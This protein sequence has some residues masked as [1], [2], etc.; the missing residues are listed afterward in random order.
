MLIYIRNRR[1][2]EFK[3]GFILLGALE[4]TFWIGILK[5]TS[6][7]LYIK[8]VWVDCIGYHNS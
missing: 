7:L 3:Y 4:R 5:L 1:F 2:K 6:F 8:D